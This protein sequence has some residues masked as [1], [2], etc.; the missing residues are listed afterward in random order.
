MA[1]PNMGNIMTEEKQPV[2][3]GFRG[4]KLAQ[5]GLWFAVYI[6]TL[7]FVGLILDKLTG[8]EFVNGTLFSVIIGGVGGAGH[9]LG[10]FAER[11]KT[12]PK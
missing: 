7:S 8:A 10:N 4:F 3:M 5:W 6:V 9:Q 11:W 1:V 12:V 2:Q